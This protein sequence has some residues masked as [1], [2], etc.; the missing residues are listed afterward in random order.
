MTK[1]K[2]RFRLGLLLVLYALI[3]FCL[4]AGVFFGGRALGRYAIEHAVY[5]PERIRAYE[6]KVFGEF[7]A[8][9]NDNGIADFTDAAGIQ[10]WFSGRSHLIVAIHNGGYA[11]TDT[12]DA[13]L[14][15]SS[16]PD[17]ASTYELLQN[18]YSDYWYACPVTV[19]GDYLRTKVVRVMYFPM[20]AAF[21]YV[22]FAAGIASFLVFGACLLLLVR[23]KTRVISRLA[24]QLE[25]MAGGDLTQPLSAAGNDELTTLAENMEEMRLSFIE[26]LRREEEMTRSSSQL[27]TDMSHDLRTP[28][29]ALI[30]YLDLVSSGKCE[31][32]ER[33]AAFIESARKRAYQIKDMT[34]ELFE[35]FLV[36]SG[37]DSELPRERVDAQTLFVQLWSDAAFALENEGFACNAQYGEAS[38]MVNA[39]PRLLTRVLDNIV[40]NIKK[41]AD[42]AFPVEGDMRAEEGFF[43]LRVRNRIKTGPQKAE[44]SGIGLASCRKIAELH[45]G[46]FSG[47][48]E[49]VFYICTLRLPAAAEKAEDSEAALPYDQ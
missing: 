24:S 35:Y 4:A 15:Y 12:N 31:D 39:S 47:K 29:T 23:R 16:V 1:P 25:V 7:I 19:K 30:G 45:G 18:E 41:Y 17:A 21:R 43:V 22:T 32:E 40:S 48:E 42:P 38:V 6:K 26:R 14:I 37:K 36:Y 33:K 9:M 20:Y 8:Y 10:P 44:S 3:S 5:T 2:R 34:D 49:D 11:F 46:D 13:T 28:L 27:L